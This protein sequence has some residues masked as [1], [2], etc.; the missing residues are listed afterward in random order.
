MEENMTFIYKIKMYVH[1]KRLKLRKKK[2]IIYMVIKWDHRQVGVRVKVR[3]RLLDGLL[4]DLWDGVLGMMTV[5]LVD[6]LGGRR[7]MWL[8]GGGDR[9]ARWEANAIRAEGLN[10]QRELTP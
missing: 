5:G 4:D 2:P 1:V 3:V 7:V 9:N 6:G 8:K 10:D